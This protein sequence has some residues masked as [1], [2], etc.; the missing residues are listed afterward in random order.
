MF[1]LG[2]ASEPLHSAT[3]CLAPVWPHSDGWSGL[4]WMEKIMSKTGNASQYRELEDSELDS[5][6]SDELNA[7]TGGV[8]SA[9]ELDPVCVELR[10]PSTMPFQHGT[11][12]VTNLHAENVDR[13]G[14]GS[15]RAGGPNGG[16][17]GG[18]YPVEDMQAKS[19]E[20]DGA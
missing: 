9:C 13:V 5:V 1:D 7:V 4:A 18:G 16:Q 20:F 15:G 12:L 6:S 19:G 3:R 14:V 8:L 11:E 10:H 17:P 2:V